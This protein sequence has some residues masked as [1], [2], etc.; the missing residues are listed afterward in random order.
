MCYICELGGLASIVLFYFLLPAEN[1]Y[2]IL[3]AVL[4]IG[5]FVVPVAPCF[6]EFASEI[7]FPVGESNVTGFLFTGAHVFGFAYGY[8][9]SAI[10]DNKTKRES[11]IV[12]LINIG[13]KYKFKDY[14]L[15]SFKIN[16][17]FCYWIYSYNI[18]KRRV[19]E[20]VS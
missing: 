8:V 10:M 18:Y 14:Y 12:L 15:N 16:R 13:K 17:S 1:T 20:V 3:P 19:K 2:V 4:G 9:A 6:I 7:A 11:N 5:L